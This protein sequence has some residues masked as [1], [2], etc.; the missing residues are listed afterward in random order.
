VASI[1]LLIFLDLIESGSDGWNF[2]L[3]G[4]K[5]LIASTYPPFE[6]QAGVNQGPRGTVQDIRGFITT[7]IHL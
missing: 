6:S 7:Q 3:E 5:K 1:F 2:H 4:A